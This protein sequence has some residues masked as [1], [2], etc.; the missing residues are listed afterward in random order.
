MYKSN[1]SRRRLHF[2][3]CLVTRPQNWGR[4]F[5][6]GALIG[7]LQDQ[8]TWYGINYTGTQIT[9]WDFQNKGTLASP[10]RL[11]FVLKGRLR[12]LHPS[13]IYSVPCY[14]ILQRAYWR[15]YGTLSVFIFYPGKFSFHFILKDSWTLKT[16]L[17]CLYSVVLGRNFEVHFTGHLRNNREMLLETLF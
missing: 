2:L 10:A 6:G 4:L 12:H 14:R 3:G 7:P 8:V 17:A 16:L 11:C 15:I 9:Q 1:N 5:K 13:V